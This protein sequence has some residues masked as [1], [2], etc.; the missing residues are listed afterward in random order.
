[1]LARELI[2]VMQHRARPLT[3]TEGGDNRKFSG[4]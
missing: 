2:E 1:M 3:G 4:Q